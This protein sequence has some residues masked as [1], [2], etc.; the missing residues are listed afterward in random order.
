MGI[1]ERLHE[2]GMELVVASGA[3]G[4][5]GTASLGS[6]VY[7]S[8]FASSTAGFG[9]DDLV[10]SVGGAEGVQLLH[11]GAILERVLLGLVM[12]TAGGL[13]SVE[14]GL[15]LVRVDDSGKIGTVHSVTVELVASLLNSLVGVGTENVIEFSKGRLA[16]NDESTDMTTRGELDKV[17]SVDVAGLDTGEVSGATLY[18]VVFVVVHNKGSSAHGE[19]RVAV[20]SLTGTHLLRLA[21]TVEVSSTTEHVDGIE[22]STGRLDVKAVSDKRKFGAVHDTVTT[23]KHKRSAGRGGKGGSNGV[24]LLVDVD[25][26]MPFPPDMEGSEHASLTALVTEST[27]A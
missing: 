19:A 22:E 14:L 1:G 21:D 8:G 18:V 6:L 3:L 23:G 9:S 13:D 5:I 20:L 4:L 25:L 11:H 24:S 16:E 17:E 27:L 7:K 2:T 26:A 12:S 15:D 10:G